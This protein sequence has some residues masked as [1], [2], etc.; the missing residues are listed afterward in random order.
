MQRVLTQ[1]DGRG[2]LTVTLNRPE[3][4]NAFDDVL[5]TE[6]TT[7]LKQA[8][9]DTEV[10]VV[11]VTGA[12]PNFSA[13][14]DLNWMRRMAGA[15]EQE[16]EHDALALAGA[17]RTLNFLN[18]PTIARV[19]GHA[20]GGGVGLMAC[21]DIVIAVDHA[22]FGITEARLG[23]APAV[24]SPYVCRRIGEHQA[25]RYFLTGERFDARTALALGLVHEIVPHGALN[26]TVERSIGQL[27]KSGPKAVR[28]CKHLAFYVSA[29][30]VDEQ[31]K[32][33]QETARLI[34]RLRVSAEGQEGLN[35]FLDK[36]PA[37][38]IEDE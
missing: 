26:D 36:R 11:V 14:A 34:A 35:A 5:I 23:L 19:N 28:E 17:M 32:T 31:L 37:A 29:N 12:D 22:R 21:C 15:S 4:H 3:I 9:R 33:D 10:R 2:V 38:W 25:R 1:L 24:I 8:E 30:D 7:V 16:N 18:R 6:L 27:L 20:F 13:G